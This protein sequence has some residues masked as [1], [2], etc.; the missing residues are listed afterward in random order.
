MSIPPKKV[1]HLG[2]FQFFDLDRLEENQNQRVASIIYTPLKINGKPGPL[3]LLGRFSHRSCMNLL[4]NSS[5]NSFCRA[6]PVCRS[7]HN[8]QQ[9]LQASHSNKWLP[10]RWGLGWRGVP[11]FSNRLRRQRRCPQQTRC[12]RSGENGVMSQSEG[13]KKDWKK[14]E[15]RATNWEVRQCSSSYEN[16]NYMDVGDGLIWGT[17]LLINFSPHPMSYCMRL[18]QWTARET[19]TCKFHEKFF[20]RRCHTKC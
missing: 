11:R 14:Y 10:H 5:F 4:G 17:W 16:T 15:L 7:P 8:H 18:L 13:H 20:G 2:A 6:F 9:M 12:Q 1:A 3:Q 19:T